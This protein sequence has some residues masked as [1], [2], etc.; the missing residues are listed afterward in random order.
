MNLQIL[1]QLIIYYAVSLFS[2]C[3]LFR[4]NQNTHPPPKKTLYD[5][6]KPFEICKKKVLVETVPLHPVSWQDTYLSTA[7]HPLHGRLGPGTMQL[8]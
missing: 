5:E 8:N 1:Y 3:I 6:D 7:P 2:K 4:L